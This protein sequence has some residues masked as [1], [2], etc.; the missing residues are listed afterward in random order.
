MSDQVHQPG[1]TGARSIAGPIALARKL[2]RRISYVRSDI[3]ARMSSSAAAPKLHVFTGSDSSETLVAPDEIYRASV[4]DLLGDVS[5]HHNHNLHRQFLVDRSS[6][7]LL[8]RLPKEIREIVYQELW[9]M[10]GFGLHIILTEAGFGHSRCLLERLESTIVEGDDAWAF[11]WMGSDS[12]ARGSV[13]LWYKREMSAWCDHWKCQ[14]A[15]DERDIWRDIAR[16]RIG[17]GV[18]VGASSPYLPMMLTCKTLY[19]ECSSSIYRSTEFTITDI[20][21]ARNLFGV[22]WKTPISHPLRRINFSFRRQADQGSTFEQWVESWSAIL[23]L[24][25]TPQLMTVNLWLDSDIYY[26]RYWL[27]VTG[28]VLRRVPEALAHK[29]AVSLPPDGHGDRIAGA[30]WL[31]GLDEVPWAAS[32]TGVRSLR[33]EGGEVVNPDVRRARV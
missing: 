30:A 26:E 23:R 10:S 31:T 9:R 24:L 27:S 15:R 17:H 13:S 11:T 16:R 21:L 4:E 3:K 33:R 7:G 28:N 5:H 25:D 14:E 1:H 12:D 22:R 18:S 20:N 32:S 8:G 29:V 2:K 6:L 19:A